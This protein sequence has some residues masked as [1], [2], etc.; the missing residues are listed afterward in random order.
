MK[1]CKDCVHVGYGTPM[2]EH[3][4][5]EREVV[6]GRAISPCFV[7]RRSNLGACG[8]SAVRFEPKPIPTP[9]PDAG[10]FVFVDPPEYRRSWIKR[11][12]GW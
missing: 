11:I 9:A 3:P 5:A 7:E 10:S 4:D 6:Y 8:P 1:L 12:L 2:C